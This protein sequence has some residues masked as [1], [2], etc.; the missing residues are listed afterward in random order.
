MSVSVA[1]KRHPCDDTISQVGCAALTRASSS[2]TEY[3]APEAPV[4]A[5]SSGGLERDG[6]RVAMDEP[7]DHDKDE[8]CD[9]DDAVHREERGIEA[10]EIVWMH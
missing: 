3:G 6:E 1:S 2:R 4:I 5:T 8:E 10:R 9:A 7:V